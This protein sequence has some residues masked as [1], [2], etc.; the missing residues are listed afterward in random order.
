MSKR[1]RLAG[2]ARTCTWTTS[3]G[4]CRTSQKTT[5]SPGSSRNKPGPTS[6]TV[7]YGF[8]AFK[9][10]IYLYY[11]IKRLIYQY[12]GIKGPIY[13]YYGMIIIVFISISY[14][15][16]RVTGKKNLLGND[17]WPTYERRSA[18]QSASG[19]NCKLW[20][21][22]PAFADFYRLIDD[23]RLTPLCRL[24]WFCKL[25]NKRLYCASSAGVRYGIHQKIR[26]KIEQPLVR[27]EI[28]VPCV[29]TLFWAV[30]SHSPCS[31]A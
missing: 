16:S 3:G 11:G 27:R 10:P 6:S 12:Y 13:Q 26:D 28:L 1:G 4:W 22:V 5:G 7:R 14:L 25:F 30:T 2:A 17:K 20:L 24:G 19:S 23:Y 15:F 18:Q 9:G 21:L 8:A 31:N 29:I